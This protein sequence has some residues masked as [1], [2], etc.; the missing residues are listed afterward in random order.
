[1][2]RPDPTYERDTTLLSH[3]IARTVHDERQRE[4]E[5]RLRFQPEACEAPP[6]LSVRKRLGLRLIRIGSTLASDGPLQLAA[7]R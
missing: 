1:M 7:R 6:R 2:A 5:R 3:Q 4:I